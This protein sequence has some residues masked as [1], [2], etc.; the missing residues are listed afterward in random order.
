MP[1]VAGLTPTLLRRELEPYGR[2]Q[3]VLLDVAG[4]HSMYAATS[5]GPFR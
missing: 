3:V 1:V 2:G 5:P 4:E